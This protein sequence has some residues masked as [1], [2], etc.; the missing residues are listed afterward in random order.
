M[1]LPAGDDTLLGRLAREA[2]TQTPLG[3]LVVPAFTPSADYLAWANANGIASRA[4]LT[5]SEF[6]DRLQEFEPSDWLLLIDP[7]SF[8]PGMLSDRELVSGLNEGPRSARHIVPRESSVAGTRERVSLDRAGHVR[9]IQR[10]YDAVTWNQATGVAATLLPV[11]GLVDCFDLKLGCLAEL[12]TALAAAGVPSRDLL[13]P[14]RAFD[15]MDEGNLL[16]LNEELMFSRMGASAGAAHGGRVESAT[17]LLGPVVLHA[18]ARVEHGATVIGPTVIGA[19]AIV[20]AHATVARAVI[21]EGIEVPPGAVVSH[22]VLA[23]GPI[24]SDVA[25]AQR[26]SQTIR[27]DT[28]G[29]LEEER[30]S[31]AYPRVK[32]VVEAFICAIG[33]TL[34]S[35]LLAII[36][37]AVRVESPGPIFY[38]DLREGLGGRVF[39]CFKFRTMVRDAHIRQRELMQNNEVDGP[40]F[41]MRRDPRVTRIGRWLRS[42]SLDELP[43]LFNVVRGDMSL[44]GPRPS[45]FRENQLCV[46]WREGRL[47]VRP[48]ITGLWQVCRH[49]RTESDFHQWIYYDLQYVRYM[50][51]WVD[52]KILIATVVTLFGRGH[53]AVEWIVPSTKTGVY[54]PSV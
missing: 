1:R 6:F 48:G 37:I 30:H 9:R 45:P 43:Q 26:F 34:I 25:A 21:A 53:V 17:R 46:P 22:Q 3:A 39:R 54:E 15:L 19:G 38:G 33:L 7:R 28:I 40:Q 8:A 12:R 14:G 27:G 44:V 2:S 52:V 11:S 35:P 36:A 24:L 41:K 47:S 16:S 23:G 51:F 49:D 13:L 32:A 50:S 5:E 20:R 29:D 10:Y 4:V 42:T 18:G 31:S